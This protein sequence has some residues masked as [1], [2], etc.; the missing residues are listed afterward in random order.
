MLAFFYH[1]RKFFASYLQVKPCHGIKI[2][3][4]LGISMLNIVYMDR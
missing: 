2:I 1:C 4:V 3:T